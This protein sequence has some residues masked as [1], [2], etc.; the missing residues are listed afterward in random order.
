MSIVQAIALDSLWSHTISH[1]NF[2]AFPS[3][4]VLSLLLATASLAVI[5]LVWLSYVALLMRFIW[6]PSLADASLPIFVGVVQFAL[7][8]LATPNRIGYWF[9]MLALLMAMVTLINQRFFRKA[10]QDPR[11]SEFF[12]GVSPATWRDLLPQFIY[13]FTGLVIGVGFLFFE[14][15]NRLA[16]VCVLLVIGAVCHFVVKQNHYWR[17]SVSSTTPTR[18][19]PDSDTA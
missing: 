17:R 10:R 1:V 5:V 15:S 8:E 6:V 12:D 11:N 4:D 16:I 3:L 9:L 7:I 14:S 2:E 18:S 13:A 19:A